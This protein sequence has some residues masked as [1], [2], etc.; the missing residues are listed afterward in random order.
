MYGSRIISCK[1]YI[2]LILNEIFFFIVKDVF[3]MLD[4][5]YLLYSKWFYRIYN[6]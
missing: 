3:C 5:Y 2:G 6:V 1:K 4:E